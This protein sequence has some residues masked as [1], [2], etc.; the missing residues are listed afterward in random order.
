MA[1]WIGTVVLV[2]V[3]GLLV[4]FEAQALFVLFGGVLLAIFLKTLAE[5]VVR[6]TRMPYWLAVVELVV[7]FVASAVGLA[8]AAGPTLVTQTSNLVQA[9]PPALHEIETRLAQYFGDGVF[10]SRLEELRPTTST[11]LAGARGA[12]TGSMQGIAA[13]VVMLFLG[14]YGALSPKSYARVMTAVLPPQ[15]RP[16]ARQVM[17]EAARRLGRWLVGRAIAMGFVAVTTCVGLLALHIPLALV[18]GVLA[19]VLTF[20]EFFGPIL[21]S[22][23]PILLALNRSPTQAAWVIVL[24]LGI[25]LVEGYILTPFI[26]RRAV[27]FPPACTLSLQALFG[28]LFGVLG[29]TFA[30]PTGIVLVTIVEL[31]WVRDVLG[32]A[33]LPVQKVSSTARSSVEASTT[34]QRVQQ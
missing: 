34:S 24:F 28:A 11:L 29:L 25:H 15:H 21:S 20:I 12:V 33:G 18:L 26:A 10:G 1:R 4:A 22:I 16:R 27:H 13:L 31:L 3:A 23:P 19:G 2:V 17:S 7:V 30:T 5:L 32:E 14:F 6:H 8:I 9:L